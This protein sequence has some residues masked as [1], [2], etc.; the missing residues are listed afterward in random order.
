MS[1]LLSYQTDFKKKNGR[2]IFATI[3]VPVMVRLTIESSEMTGCILA[4]VVPNILKK[5]HGALTVMMNV[6]LQNVGNHS[7]SDT[8]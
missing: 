3:E 2:M 6:I 4:Q 7:Y 5:D 8:V 1:K